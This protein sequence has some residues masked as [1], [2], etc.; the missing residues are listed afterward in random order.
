MKN[1]SVVLNG[2]LFVAVIVLYVLYFSGSK[3]GAEFGGAARVH[4]DAKIVY[5]NMDSLLNNYTQSREL[6][7]AYLKKV[8]ANRTELNVKVRQWS[9]DAE[10][11]Q[12]KVDNNGFLTKERANQEYTD[13]MIRK[14]NLERLEQEMHETAL[15]EQRELNQRL[16]D[17]FTS[18]LKEYNRDKGYEIVL[19]TT[20]GGTVF[21][22]ESGYDITPDVVKQLNAKYQSEK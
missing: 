18:F 4:G 5:L 14:E 11:F 8:E 19:S 2:I 1:L 9:K 12:R 3:G 10:E 7:E 21:Y 16:F 6:N 15:R 13:I 20:L 17:I 22:A